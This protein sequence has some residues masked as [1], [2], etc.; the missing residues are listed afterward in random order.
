MSKLIWDQLNEKLYETGVEQV[1]LYPQVNG[2]YPNGVAWNGVT[3][4]TVTPSGAEATP[5]YA[6]NRKYLSLMSAEEIGGSISAYM[7]PDEFAECD[8]SKSV[9]E[10]VYFGQQTR[11]PFG[12]VAK[13][14]IGNDTQFNKY[15]YKLHLIYNALASVS[16]KAYSSVNDSPEVDPM[17]WEYTT[18]PLAVTG[19]EPTAYI[20]IDSTK[21]DAAKLANLEKILY[22][23][24]PTVVASQPSDWATNYKNYFTKSGDNYIAVTGESAPTFSTGT[25]YTMNNPRLPL[26]AEIAT[27]MSGT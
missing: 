9:V 23:D 13:T 27:I 10:G 15:G 22:G 18:T 12:L 7:Y 5:L 19:Y 24:G 17:S 20:C 4:F 14:L 2:S 3:E 1:A 8:G 6:N 26:P 21:V 25:Y 16:E 11:K